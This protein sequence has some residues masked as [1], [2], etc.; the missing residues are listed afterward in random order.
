M[1][2]PERDAGDY[3]SV[4]DMRGDGMS[5][6]KFDPEKAI[7]EELLK[8]NRQELCLFVS[9]LCLQI[10]AEVGSR[11]YRGGIFPEN[12]CVNDSGEIAIGPARLEKWSGQEL[13]FVA[14]EL[15]WDGK[16]SPAADVY[17]LGLLLYYGLSGGKLPFA[18]AGNSG[19]LARVGGK[20]IRAPK[21]A[22][23]R[24]GEIVEKA[25]AFRAEDRYQTPEELQIMLESCLDNKYLGAAGAEAVFQKQDGELSDIERLM[26]DIM[27][28][29]EDQKVEEPEETSAEEPFLVAQTPE[30][31]AGLEKPE[32]KPTQEENV[33]QLVEEFF[34]SLS[35]AGAAEPSKGETPESGSDETE[36]VRVYEPSKEKK[37]RTGRQPIPILTEEKYPDLE[38]VVL[39]QPWSNWEDQDREL[40]Q[41]VVEEVKKRRGVRPLAVVLGLC[42]LL[43]IGA[44]IVNAILNQNARSR[45]IAAN[46]G[47]E[48][49]DLES[50][51]N[52]ENTVSE[53]PEESPAVQTE[54]PAPTQAP[55]QYTVVS[56]DM[57][58]LDAQAACR[59][60]GGYLAV[61]STREEFDQITRLA[62]EQGLTRLWIGCHRENDQLVWETD[63]P[64]NFTNWADNEPSNW[65][66][67]DNVPED[68]VMI[69]KEDGVWYYNDNRNDPAADYP[70]YYSGTMGYVCEFGIQ[71]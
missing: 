44:L 70:E 47:N 68:Y 43:V 11:T 14:P 56:S 42:V 28:T 38:P 65:D 57:S 7:G 66:Y 4:S 39:K 5:D 40:P 24:L 26:V 34:G 46:A 29:G 55:P 31:Q 32:P 63:D 19:Q 20:A 8:K 59:G 41:E 54:Q 52:E 15:Y 37:E 21:G 35:A 22:G 49:P 60:Q 33:T 3:G 50:F 67:W 58:W 13:E 53:Q 48:L 25:V 18:S 71:N 1:E 36:D 30:E 2:S 27:E 17:S 16:T 12:I 23:K 61:I 62:D 69:Y 10:K 51:L 45:Q 64:V 6:W 9:R